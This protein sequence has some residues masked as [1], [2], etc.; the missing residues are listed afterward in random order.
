MF[1]HFSAKKVECAKHQ[2][3]HLVGDQPESPHAFE[4]F[5]V[6]ARWRSTWVRV[7][8]SLTLQSSYKPSMHFTMTCTMGCSVLGRGAEPLV[9]TQFL[10]HPPTLNFGANHLKKWIQHP[11]KPPIPFLSPHNPH[12]GGGFWGGGQRVRAQLEQS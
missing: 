5:V 6:N 2:W 10:E 7:Y 12:H 4:N 1:L 8:N 9:R 3:I 11:Q